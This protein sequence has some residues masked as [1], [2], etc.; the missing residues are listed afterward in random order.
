MMRKRN[1]DLKR[2][3]RQGTA[4]RRFGRSKEVSEVG[5]NLVGQIPGYFAFC[6]KKVSEKEHRKVGEQ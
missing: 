2:Q 6:A 1:N 5:P 4:E 3:E